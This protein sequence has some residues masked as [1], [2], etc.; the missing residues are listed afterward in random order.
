MVHLFNPTS[1]ACAYCEVKNYSTSINNNPSAGNDGD[2]ILETIMAIYHDRHHF[3][4]YHGTI[5]NNI[6]IL[7]LPH[8]S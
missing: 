4:H 8:K 3:C 6:S 2:N 5:P 7:F 1:D